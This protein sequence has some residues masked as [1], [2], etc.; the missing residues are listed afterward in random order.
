[1]NFLKK[2][3]DNEGLTCSSVTI[4]C[5]ADVSSVNDSGRLVTVLLITFKS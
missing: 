5:P 1:M 3:R 2:R 4:H